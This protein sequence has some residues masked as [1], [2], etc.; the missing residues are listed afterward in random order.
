MTL[1]LILSFIATLTFSLILSFNPVTQGTFIL[2]IALTSTVIL[3]LIS[4]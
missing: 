1:S 3:L 4:S 2:L